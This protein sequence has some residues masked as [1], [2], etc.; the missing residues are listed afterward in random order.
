MEMNIC[1]S[2]MYGWTVTP[3]VVMPFR[4]KQNLVDRFGLD[5]SKPPEL[6]VSILADDDPN[7]KKMLEVSVITKG[8]EGSI[9]RIVC[10]FETEEQ[11]FSRAR[12]QKAHAIEYESLSLI[13][14]NCGK[15]SV[16]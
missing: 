14:R 12:T 16:M 13:Y 1:S 3:H 5:T 11:T 6:L 2:D 10:T 9:L 15:Q 4:I 7:T 8:V